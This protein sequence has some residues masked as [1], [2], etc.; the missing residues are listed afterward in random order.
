MSLNRR[1]WLSLV[2]LAIIMGL[3]LFIP[4]GKVDYWQGWVYLSIFFGAAAL[5]T[6]TS[7]DGTL[8]SSN[9]E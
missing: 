7:S 2:V 3:L 8:P 4:A 1:A 5:T 9:V 6:V